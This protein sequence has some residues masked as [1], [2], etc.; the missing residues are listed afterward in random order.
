MS[1]WHRGRIVLG[2]PEAALARE[3]EGCVDALVSRIREPH[4]R[5]TDG[6]MP[7]PPTLEE[8]VSACVARM[9]AA[10]RVL[11]PDATAW[12]VV[13]DGYLSPD[14]PKAAPGRGSGLRAKQMTLCGERLVLALQDDGWW[15][16]SRCIAEAAGTGPEPVA[17]RPPRRVE[18]VWMLAP[19]RRYR[20]YGDAW[21]AHV[22]TLWI[23]GGRD[24]QVPGAEDV[25]V[26]RCL[27]LGTRAH[28]WILDPFA[29]GSRVAVEALHAGRSALALCRTEEGAERLAAAGREVMPLFVEVRQERIGAEEST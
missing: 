21:D 29:D 23:L 2:S 11:R 19:Q 10:R 16:R 12:L 17:D 18:T 5:R 4:E 13:G 7:P 25:V 3:P 27:R 1:G 24:A 9:A 28:G 26:Q 22:G 6:P 8:W 15:V 20:W 14:R